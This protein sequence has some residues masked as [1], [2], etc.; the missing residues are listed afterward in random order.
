MAYSSNAILTK[1]RA[2]SA[3]LLSE[4]NFS[5]MLAVTS[6][7]DV[8]AYLSANTDFHDEL[9]SLPTGYVKRS[10]LENALKKHL[11]KQFE[12]LAHFEKAIGQDLYRY[13][14]IRNEIDEIVSCIR[15]LKTPN[16]DEYLLKMPVFLN[17]LTSIDLFRLAKSQTYDDIVKS[18]EGTDY[19]KI[20][21]DFH[22]LDGKI[23]LPLI[24]S[25]LM[26]YLNEKTEDLAKKSLSKKENEE[27]LRALRTVSDMKNITGIYRLKFIFKYS[28]EKIGALILTDKK[29]NIDIKKQQVLLSCESE[30]DFWNAVYS[31]PYGS[32]MK[33][34]SLDLTI[35]NRCQ[36]FIVNWAKK[37][38]RFS[39]YPSVVMFCWILLSE[40][41]IKNI[42][43]LAAGIKYEIP[44]EEIERNLIIPKEGDS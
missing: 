43:R 35:E 5:E 32:G 22:S 2:M 28:D 12:S 8:A 21:K 36:T 7:A 41:E 3:N 44:A 25:A 34:T 24:E 30:E 15:L 31:T 16:A 20:L 27:F 17:K 29:S 10:M 26:R 13:F 40:N 9:A 38:L 23:N 33:K 42:I 19:E 18:V 11:F 39:V 1:A 4:K 37:M 14:I 6:V